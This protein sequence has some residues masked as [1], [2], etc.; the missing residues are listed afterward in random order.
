M[1]FDVS[2][3]LFDVSRI[4]RF[5]VEIMNTRPENNKIVRNSSTLEMYLRNSIPNMS[6]GRFFI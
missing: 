4:T 6:C 5:N 1:K 3:I 2:R